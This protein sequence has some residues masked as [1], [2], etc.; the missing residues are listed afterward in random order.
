[1]KYIWK[2]GKVAEDTISFE[3]GVNKNNGYLCT[4]IVPFS[5][6]CR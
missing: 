2:S 1:M 3:K 6:Y 4:Q 5:K